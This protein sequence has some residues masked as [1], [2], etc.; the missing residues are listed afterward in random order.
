MQFERNLTFIQ[1]NRSA[2]HFLSDKQAGVYFPN[3]HL[4]LLDG[5]YF[6]ILKKHYHFGKFALVYIKVLGFSK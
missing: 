2:A 1:I 3:L 5:C 6:G 4:Q